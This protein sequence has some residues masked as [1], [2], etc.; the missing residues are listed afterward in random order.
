MK[1]NRQRA[2]C[3][4]LVGEHLPDLVNGYKSIPESLKREDNRGKTP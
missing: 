1:M 2:K 3:V 4:K